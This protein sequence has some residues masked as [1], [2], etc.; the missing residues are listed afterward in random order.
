M[1]AGDLLAMS[2]A[3]GNV[4]RAAGPNTWRVGRLAIAGAIMVLLLLALCSAVVGMGKFALAPQIDALRTFAFVAM[5]FG[6]GSM[7]AI[8]D[9]HYL[10]RARPGNWLIASSGADVL[11]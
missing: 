6:G 7:I 10:R 3:T 4:V 8:R 11:I 2:M 5:L 1:V 9:R